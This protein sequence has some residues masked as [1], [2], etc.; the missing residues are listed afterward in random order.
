VP[1]NQSQ[2]DGAALTSDA[3][4]ESPKPDSLLLLG[5]TGSGKTPLGDELE[6]SALWERR[7]HHFDFGAN[8]RAVVAGGGSTTFEAGEIG[9]LRRVLEEG[10]LLE[11]RQF[12]LA[13]RILD[14]FIIDRQVQPNDVL[15]LNGL[16]RHPAQAEAIAAHASVIGV[17][18]LEC[19]PRVVAERLR[20]DTGGDRTQRTDDTESLVA[21]KL[22]IYEERTRPLVDFYRHRGVPILRIEVGVGTQAVDLVRQLEIWRVRT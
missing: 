14:G 13:A 3:P 21:R 19:G 1:L 2:C 20:Q 4:V 15:V 16:P 9:F 5:P 8:L 7:C 11:D 10:A 12:P 18:Q 6:R 17:I 22:A